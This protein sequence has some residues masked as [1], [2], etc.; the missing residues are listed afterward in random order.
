MK[1]TCMY[2]GVENSKQVIQEQV[3]AGK[4]V[5]WESDA[6]TEHAQAMHD[7]I[8]SFIQTNFSSYL[9]LGELDIGGLR[10]MCD[11]P[12]SEEGHSE[13]DASHAGP[14]SAPQ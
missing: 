9:R 12:D 5:S 3:V 14:S 13:G 8:K 1:M 2:V 10:Q 11:E 6:T 4:S 7:A